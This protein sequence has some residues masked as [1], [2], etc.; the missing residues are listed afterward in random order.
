MEVKIVKRKDRTKIRILEAL[1]EKAT[2]NNNPGRVLKNT[3]PKPNRK[4]RRHSGRKTIFCDDK[5]YPIQLTFY[6]EW[7]NY[8]DGMSHGNL[9]NLKHYFKNYRGCCCQDEEIIISINKKI[10]KQIKIRKA[11]KKFISCFQQLANH[12]PSYLF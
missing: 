4:T 6:D 2:L 3:Y 1:Q 10:K 5:D 11:R 12:Q 7:K 8:K 9:N